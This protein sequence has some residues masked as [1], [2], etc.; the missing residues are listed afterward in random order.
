[1]NSPITIGPPDLYINSTAPQTVDIIASC[2]AELFRTA[3]LF[4]VLG[5]LAA[6]LGMIAAWIILKKYPDIVYYF[7]K[8]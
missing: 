1:M 2:N 8:P 7:F 3:Q 6:V 5:A 4:T